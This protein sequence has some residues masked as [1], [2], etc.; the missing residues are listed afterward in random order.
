M[1]GQ[2]A[3]EDWMEHSH[4]QFSSFSGC[5]FILFF[6]FLPVVQYELI[7]WIIKKEMERGRN[8]TEG[9]DLAVSFMPV[10]LRRVGGGSRERWLCSVRSSGKSL[11]VIPV[12]LQ[13][14]KYFFCSENPLWINTSIQ[15]RFIVHLKIVS[16][17]AILPPVHPVPF[18]FTLFVDRQW[19]APERPHLCTQTNA[20]AAVGPFSKRTYKVHTG[21]GHGDGDA[22]TERDW[23]QV[24][25]WIAKPLRQP[26][27]KRISF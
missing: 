2:W 13:P 6:F 8:G 26:G 21:G 5:C 25:L 27:E 23:C 7:C 1:V 4:R 14:P 16:V 10:L 3:V 15:R 17:H 9:A 12:Q 11:F 24:T 19:R 22:D 20:S 18:L